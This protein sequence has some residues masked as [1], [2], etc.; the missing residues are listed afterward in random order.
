MDRKNS[1][2]EDGSRQ[3]QT[4]TGQAAAYAI[5][6]DLRVNLMLSD[7]LFFQVPGLQDE[8][9]STIITE[10]HRMGATFHSTRQ[11]KTDKD[12]Q[13]RS[14]V[15]EMTCPGAGKAMFHFQLLCDAGP[16]EAN[17]LTLWENASFGT[18][19]R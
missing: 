16:G 13:T 11:T 12:R 10:P 5:I 7:R 1:N 3:G 2:R 6:A 9:N 15:T 17:G 4:R 14:C 8:L 19:I 18:G